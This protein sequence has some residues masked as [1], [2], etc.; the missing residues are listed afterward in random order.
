MF[1]LVTLVNRTVHSSIWTCTY[2]LPEVFIIG[3]RKF[4]FCQFVLCFLPFT[5]EY[6]ENTVQKRTSD[7]VF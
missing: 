2:E 6:E 5:M 7:I 3:H 1:G 4:C